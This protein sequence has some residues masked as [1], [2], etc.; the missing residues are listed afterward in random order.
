MVHDKTNLVFQFQ[1]DYSMFTNFFH[2]LLRHWVGN[3]IPVQ[4]FSNTAGSILMGEKI[5]LIGFD[6][7]HSLGRFH[8]VKSLR[9][10]ENEEAKYEG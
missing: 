3:F 10:W 8:D 5:F 4:E 2:D 9:K 7:K 6:Q 1:I